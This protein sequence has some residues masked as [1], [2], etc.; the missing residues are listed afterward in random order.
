[1]ESLMIKASLRPPPRNYGKFFHIAI[2][3]GFIL[4]GI[5]ILFMDEK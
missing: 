1:M 2:G 3:V 5:W 4:I